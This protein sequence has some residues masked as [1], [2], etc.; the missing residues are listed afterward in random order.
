MGGRVQYVRPYQYDQPNAPLPIPF[1]LVPL[2]T[3]KPTRYA[4]TSPV[5][6]TDK[7]YFV[8]QFNRTKYPCKGCYFTT[9]YNIQVFKRPRI[10]SP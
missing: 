7:A 10:L 1:G 8:R 9:T 6:H 2:P 4:H 3:T 5:I